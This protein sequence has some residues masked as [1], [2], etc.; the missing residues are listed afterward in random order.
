MFIRVR[1]DP[2]SVVPAVRRAIQ[3]VRP[4]LPLLAVRL[5]RDR[6][7]PEMRP[8]RLAASMFS[9][10]GGV[11]LL[12]AI[13]GLYGVVAFVAAQRSSEIAVRIALGARTP[14]VLAVTGTEALRAVGVGLIV[15]VVA[16][17]LASRWIGPLL[18]QTSPND[19][20]IILG[21]ATVLLVVATA[22]SLIPTLRALRRNTAAI[23][24]VD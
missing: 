22:A 13:V 6:I 9:L 16:A 8:W 24:R 15:G 14:H 23:L 2:A 21:A 5:M 12:I 20:G 7:D 18:F 3:S 11:A 10:F 4:A 19:P 17:S 1:G